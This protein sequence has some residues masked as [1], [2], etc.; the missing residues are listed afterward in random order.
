LKAL[1]SSQIKEKQVLQTL[2]GLSQSHLQPLKWAEQIYCAIDFSCPRVFEAKTPIAHIY[3]IFDPISRMLACIGHYSP[4]VFDQVLNDYSRP[5]SDA[6]SKILKES[7]A[8]LKKLGMSQALIEQIVATAKAS[9]E[10]IYKELK[11]ATTARQD[12]A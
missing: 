10:A 11:E 3:S 4:A 9:G 1:S 12:R 5:L 7:K 2:R 8:A 6:Q